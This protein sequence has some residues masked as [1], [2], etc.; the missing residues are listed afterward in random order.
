MENIGH[1]SFPMHYGHTGQH[2]RHPSRC[3]PSGLFSG[4]LAIFRL[5][6][7]IEPTRPTKRSTYLWMK[8]GNIDFSNFRSYKSWGTM[9]T[10]MRQSTKRRRRPFTTDTSDDDHSRSTTRF[11]SAILASSSFLGSYALDG[12]VITCFGV[13]RRRIGTHL[14]YRIRSTIQGKRPSSQA[15]PDIKATH[16]SR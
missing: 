8:Q 10:R 2:T 12:M 14:R 11:G 9:R 3:L 15:V 16:T 13:F 5:S 4:K 7:S 6:V 1:T